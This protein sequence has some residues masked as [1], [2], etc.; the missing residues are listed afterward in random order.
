MVWRA[1]DAADTLAREDGVEAEVVNVS[2]IKPLASKSV[3]KSLAKTGVAV[4]AEEHRIVGG[5]ADAIRQV[6]AEQHPVPVF[7]LGMKDEFGIS[8]TAEAC[9]EHFNLTA[10]GIADLVREAMVKKPLVQHPPISGN[11]FN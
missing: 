7:A 8:G 6:A 5:L 2:I 10:T 4:T 11:G 3:L 1:L 9:M